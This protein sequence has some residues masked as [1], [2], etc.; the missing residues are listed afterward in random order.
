MRDLYTNVKI[1]S[2]VSC[3]PD[4][5]YP[6]KLDV[7]GSLRDV[8]CSLRCE[9]VEGS[10]AVVWIDGGRSW[11]IIIAHNPLAVISDNWG[12]FL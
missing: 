11:Y 12:I 1:T 6:E 5:V 8:S 7:F 4:V 9:D 3:Y 2:D 10:L